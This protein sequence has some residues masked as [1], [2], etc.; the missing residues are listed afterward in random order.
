MHYLSVIQIP[1]QNLIRSKAR[2]QA[3]TAWLARITHESKR[4]AINSDGSSGSGWKCERLSRENQCRLCYQLILKARQ[5][6]CKRLTILKAHFWWPAHKINTRIQEPGNLFMSRTLATEN[7]I[8]CL[9]ISRLL[10]F[11]IWSNF[12]YQHLVCPLENLIKMVSPCVAICKQILGWLGVLNWAVIHK[13]Y[14]SYLYKIYYFK[15]I[16]KKIQTR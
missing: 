3:P 6:L 8:F 1:T 11:F 9:F 7:C 2:L 13:S 10:A 12:S 16:I 15:A 14:R 5:S 4:R